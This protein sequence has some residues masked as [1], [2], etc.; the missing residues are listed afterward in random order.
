[1]LGFDLSLIIEENPSV[2]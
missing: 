1:M 2:D